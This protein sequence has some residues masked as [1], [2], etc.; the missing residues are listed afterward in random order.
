MI[1]SRLHKQNGINS[2]CL[3]CYAAPLHKR[4]HSSPFKT[5]WMTL[6]LLV[7]G[8]VSDLVIHLPNI[9]SKALTQ[10]LF[11]PQEDHKMEEFPVL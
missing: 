9:S 11:N 6:L 3:V 10:Q 5:Q 4:G 8:T 1:H 7:D 2:L